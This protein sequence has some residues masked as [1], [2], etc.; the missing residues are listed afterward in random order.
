MKENYR[1]SQSAAMLFEQLAVED[2]LIEQSS[3]RAIDL[4]T[5]RPIHACKTNAWSE[6]N[7]IENYDAVKMQ[8]KTGVKQ[9]IESVVLS[10]ASQYKTA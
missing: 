6:D 1:A 8:L 3:N 4:Q 7:Q 10:G 5:Y 9:L 2:F